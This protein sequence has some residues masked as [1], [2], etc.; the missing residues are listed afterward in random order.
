MPADPDSRALHKHCPH[1]AVAQSLFSSTDQFWPFKSGTYFCSNIKRK[2]TL[3]TEDSTLLQDSI[4]L[5]VLLSQVL[6]LGQKPVIPLKKP[7]TSLK[8]KTYLSYTKSFN[9][10]WAGIELQVPIAQQQPQEKK[11]KEKKRQRQKLPNEFKTDIYVRT[12][13]QFT[14]FLIPEDGQNRDHLAFSSIIV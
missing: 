3:L 7:Q 12:V 14:F 2:N 9:Q 11:K 5:C 6:V 4:L 8:C 1:N 13:S 10:N